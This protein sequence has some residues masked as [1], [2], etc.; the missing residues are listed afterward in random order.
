MFPLSP[1]DP[2]KYEGLNAVRARVKLAPT[3]NVPDKAA[4]ADVVLNERK[5]EL[6]YVGQRRWDLI[7]MGKLATLNG[8]Y[9]RKVEDK[10]VVFPIP[11]TELDLNPN[12]TQNAGY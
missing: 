10:H 7:R 1:A 11:Q 4:F 8:P 2:K 6:C 12:L 5:F 9:G 3:A